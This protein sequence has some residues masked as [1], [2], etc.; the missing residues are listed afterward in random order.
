MLLLAE[1]CRHE[2]GKGI[3]GASAWSPPLRGGGCLHITA[4]RVIST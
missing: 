3:G 2:A 4:S 1:G